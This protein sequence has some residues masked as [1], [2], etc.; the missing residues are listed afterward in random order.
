VSASHSEPPEI[1]RE[2]TPRYAEAMAET[3]KAPPTVREARAE[4]RDEITRIFEAIG[5]DFRPGDPGLAAAFDE[6]ERDRGVTLVAEVDGRV[7]GGLAF[8][9][10]RFGPTDAADTLWIDALAV[11]DRHRRHGA[12][13]ALMDETLRRARAAGCDTVLV[14][15]HEE[16]EA[17]MS[18]YAGVGFE[19]HG[20][21]LRLKLG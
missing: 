15:T 5:A 16:M 12:A 17:A 20:L 6:F 1:Q 19:R 8:F 7:A 18:L 3:T 2:R 9:I 4:D 10:R 21:Y 11:E 14:H 13:R